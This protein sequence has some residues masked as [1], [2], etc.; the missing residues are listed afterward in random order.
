MRAI[1][2]AC[3]MWLRPPVAAD[4]PIFRPCSSQAAGTEQEKLLALCMQCPPCCSGVVVCCRVEEPDLVRLERLHGPSANSNLAEATLR[5]SSNLSTVMQH[6]KPMGQEVCSSM[7]CT[8]SHALQH[9]SCGSPA[10]TKLPISTH[11]MA[12]HGFVTRRVT[13]G[14]SVR[15]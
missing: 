13:W 8:Y 3:Q 14:L 7:A 12:N 1:L 2:A 11:L 10:A 9:H 4:T 15:A 5:T 6:W